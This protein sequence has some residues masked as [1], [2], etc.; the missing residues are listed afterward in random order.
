MAWYGLESKPYVTV[1]RPD[2]Y[3]SLYHPAYFQARVPAAVCTCLSHTFH[4]LLALSHF[5]PLQ[6][7]RNE[8]SYVLF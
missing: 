1:L 6:L 5:E 8:M 3:N 4:A 2:F 7:T